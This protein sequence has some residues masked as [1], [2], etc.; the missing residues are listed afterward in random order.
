MLFSGVLVLWPMATT[1]YL[2]RTG[3]PIFT[4]NPHK[5]VGTCAGTH[6]NEVHIAQEAL[7]VAC[8]Y[9]FATQPVR[10]AFYL[11]A[12]ARSATRKA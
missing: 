5:C 8:F 11:W 1:A 9:L 3:G 2:R 12:I 4:G 10:L 7:P 6:V